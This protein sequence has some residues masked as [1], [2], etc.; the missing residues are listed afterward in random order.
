MRAS[1]SRSRARIA[2]SLF[3]A[4]AVAALVPG[5]SGVARGD[6]PPPGPGG[7]VYGY[8]EGKGAIW[9]K[10]IDDKWRKLTRRSETTFWFVAD[11]DGNARGEATTTYAADLQAIKWSIALPAGSIEASVEGR[12]EAKKIV[13]P[14]EGTVTR[15]SVS[16]KAVGED[17]EM[18]VPG[19]GFDF[20]IYANVT[21]PLP[22]GTA[23]GLPQLMDIKIPAKGWSPF[24]ALSAPVVKRPHGPLVASAKSAGDK[25]SIE[26]EAMRNPTYDLDA[27]ADELF[28][29]LEPR[30]EAILVPK[31][32]LILEPKIEATLKPIIKNELTIELK[33]VIKNELK[34]E[35]KPEIKN[36]LKIE[37]KPEIKAELKLELKAEIEAELKVELEAILKPKIKLELKP[38]LILEIKAEL[39][40]WIEQTLNQWFET[41]LPPK[42]E[43]AVKPIRTEIKDIEERL[44]ALEAFTLTVKVVD[45]ATG[46]PVPFAT[47]EVVGTKGKAAALPAPKDGPWALRIGKGGYTVNARADG[48]SGSQSVDLTSDQTITI[49]L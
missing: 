10:A 37:L 16:L 17:S 29:M 22:A 31:L 41:R 23:A 28:D 34:V 13:Y 38:E 49:T 14:I 44:A 7:R 6:P 21:L 1:K 25:F 27:L 8:W 18:T 19:T 42:I 15:E 48:R 45:R 11:K 47:V 9:Q 24:Q 46:Q 43:E 2:V 32:V 26:W 30:L 12:S 39:Q 33:P 4:V 20:V 3:A 35:L 40:V 36:E 5:A